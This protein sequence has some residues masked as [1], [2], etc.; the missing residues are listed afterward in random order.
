MKA[1]HFDRKRIARRG[2]APLAIAV[3]VA[4]SMFFGPASAQD[5]DADVVAARAAFDKGDAAAL[6]AIAPRVADHVL[7]PYVAMWQLD[8]AVDT[9]DPQAVHA[10]LRRWAGTPFADRLAVDWLKSRARRGDWAAF[11]TEY[12]PRAAADT[13]L[14]CDAVLYH[15]VRDGDAALAE[16]RP[17]WFTGQSTPDAC[18]PLFADLVA[19]QILDTDDRAARVRLAA[20]AGNWRLVRTLADSLP[21]DARVSGAAFAAV[22]RDPVRT[23]LRGQFQWKRTSG[24]ILAL[25]ALER[26]GRSDASAA[27][28]AWVKWRERLPEEARGYGNARIA[29]LGARQLE[30]DANL[31][32]READVARENPDERAWRVRAALRGGDW[33]DVL[34]AIDALPAAMADEPA[35]RYWRARALAQT[36]RGAE[37]TP[38]YAALATADYGFYGLLAAEALGRRPVLASKP[39]TPSDVWL[40]NFGARDDVRRVAKLAALDMRADSIREWAAV[41]RAMDDQTLLY[42]AEFARRAGLP[43]RSI[44]TAERTRV[45]HDF[46]LRYPTPYEAQFLA[47]AQATGVEAPLLYGVARQ[48]SRF[49]A[50]IVSAAGAMGLMQLMPLTARWVSKQMNRPDYR[51][52]AITDIELNAAFGAFYLKYW[53]D[54]LDGQAALAAAAYN[55]GPRRAD[56]WRPPR[57]LEGAI[58]V[59]TIPF[60]ETRDYV[61]KVLANTV[62]YASI[63]GKP[64]VEAPTLGARLG[65]IT[66]RPATTALAPG[67]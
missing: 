35:W 43:D 49:V 60:N 26:A 8:L 50:D 27:H 64:G 39:A 21:G 63:L 32:Y 12:P 24:R 1:M 15:R 48:E 56:A 18:E 40:A 13:E 58:W 51:P 2:P 9:A 33:N 22:E 38:I 7:A 4:G 19:R 47:A 25:Y 62:Y 41:V 53:L 34:A 29:F 44:N 30:P 16:A 55:A 14:A 3:L 54:R 46:A 52:D 23:L 59:E 6:A 67:S 61:K 65:T 20:E 17:L 11:A 45:R 28:A 37:A 10:F 31:W 66:P 5:P 57:A 36:G 42:A